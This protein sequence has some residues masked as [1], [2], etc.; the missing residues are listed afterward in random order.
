M[1]QFIDLA[2][3]RYGRLLVVSLARRDRRSYWNCRCDCGTERVLDNHVLRT[4]N[5]TS[6]GCMKRDQTIERLTTHGLAGTRYYNLWCGVVARCYNTNSVG[7][8]NYG[9]RGIKM[10][11]G[12]RN[13]PAAFVAWCKAQEPIPKGYTLDRR[14]NDGPYSPGNCRFASSIDQARNARSNIRVQI[15]GRD[16]VL[17]EAAAKYSD[18]SYRGVAMRVSRGW[19]PRDA[20]LTP[21]QRRATR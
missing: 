16:M 15:N 10:C 1:G 7:F 19:S 5:T 3:Q 2:G 17:T 12:W 8:K 14:N 13:D 6:C 4:G 20:V 9:G 11:R 18:I 21:R